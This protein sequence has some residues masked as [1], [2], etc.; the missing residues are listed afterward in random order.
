MKLLDRSKKFEIYRVSPSDWDLI[1]AQIDYIEDVAFGDGRESF[2]ELEDIFLDPEN[3]CLIAQWLS[4][5]IICGYASGGPLPKFRKTAKYP[6]TYYSVE[7]L[8]GYKVFYLDTIAVLEEYRRNGIGSTLT[9]NCVKEAKM[10][11]YKAITSHCINNISQRM[12]NKLGFIEM[13]HIKINDED[14]WYIV[15]IL[16]S[17]DETE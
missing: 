4:N 16:D 10:D 9:K 1:S 3:I 6:E 14:S 2:S 15:L 11:N 12:V 13:K 5:D 8:D 17:E 7:G